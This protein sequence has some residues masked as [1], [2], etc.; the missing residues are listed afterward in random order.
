LNNRQATG[1]IDKW[2]GGIVC[3]S[4]PNQ[5]AKLLTRMTNQYTRAHGGASWGRFAGG[6][7]YVWRVLASF[8]LADV[9]R[10][11]QNSIFSAGAGARRA[12]GGW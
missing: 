8:V 4:C 2:P 12:T 5:Q 7:V 11:K 6:P 9:K 1:G 3:K 10:Q